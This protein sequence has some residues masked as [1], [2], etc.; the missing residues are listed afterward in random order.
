MSTKEVTKQSKWIIN[1]YAGTLSVTSTSKYE[2]KI[3]KTI[4]LLTM[5]LHVKT[6]FYTIT[7]AALVRHTNKNSLKVAR[8]MSEINYASCDLRIKQKEIFQ[9]LKPRH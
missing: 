1:N 9:V 4:L 6:T 5:L 8:V 2:S 3:F 7:R